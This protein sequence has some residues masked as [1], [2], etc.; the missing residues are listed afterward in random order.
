MTIPLAPYPPSAIRTSIPPNDWSAITQSWNTALALLLQ[1]PSTQPSDNLTAFLNSYLASAPIL[2]VDALRRSVFLLLHRLLTDSPKLLDTP[3]F[4]EGFARL[5]CNVPTAQK[6]LESLWKNHEAEVE[7][8]VK[9]LKKKHLP[10]FSK[11]NVTYN[12]AA[13]LSR[14][15]QLSPKAAAT[16]LAGEEFVDVALDGAEVVVKLYARAMTEAARVNWSVVVDALYSLTVPSSGKKEKA[17]ARRLAGLRLG[18]MLKSMSNGTESESRVAAVVEKLHELSP[19]PRK[20]KSKPALDKGKGIAAPESSPGP[21]RSDQQEAETASKV[22]QIRDMFPHLGAGFVRRCLKEIGS[23]EEVTMALLEQNLPPQLLEADQSEEFFPP[24]SV[25]F[26]RPSFPSPS[27]V[28]KPSLPER[29][30][31]YD[32][33]AFDIL[34]PSAF[35]NLTVGKR[36]NSATADKLLKA[37]DVPKSAI[38]S[39]LEAFDSDEDERDDTYDSN[40]VGGAVDVVDDQADDEHVVYMAY[41]R[42]AADFLKDARGG[43]ARKAL[44]EA[45]GWTDEQLE[46]WGVML[47]REPDRQRRLERKFA[48]REMESGRQQQVQLE[49]TSWRT[50]DAESERGRARG[51]GRGGRGRGG[52]GREGHVAPPSGPSAVSNGS[53]GPSG[54]GSGGP[55]GNPQQG[56]NPGRGRARKE[57]NKGRVGNHNRREGH[58]KKLA[59]GFGGG[60]VE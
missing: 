18:P 58:A 12:D 6:L 59:R 57:Q 3:E 44:K 27:P 52:P 5:Y 22:D 49:R 56:T 34:A 19:P 28:P 26:A 23:V 48:A 16:F 40:D 47:A 60:P 1:T 50:G 21:A 53:G 25:Q 55:G 2:P 11:A 17:L 24:E 8:A 14:I 51:R 9:A 35:R 13:S 36:H 15:F 31:V 20:V 39:A 42:S 38:L 46:G 10:V 45:T 4:L 7:K 33:D 37:S 43:T 32:N 30:N 54:S 29:K 41:Q